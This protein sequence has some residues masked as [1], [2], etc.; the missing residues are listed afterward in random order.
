[1]KQEVV[2]ERMELKANQQKEG[3]KEGE[4]KG[5]ERRGDGRGGEGRGREERKE[6]K[7][8]EKEKKSCVLE[9]DPQRHR[10][11]DLLQNPKIRMTQSQV[12]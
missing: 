11:I 10:S 6:K 8:K 12:H 3:R 1:M 9:S 2:E 4:R 5:E 7:R